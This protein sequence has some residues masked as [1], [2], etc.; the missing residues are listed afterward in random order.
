VS[1]ITDGTGTTNYSYYPVT[2]PSTLGAA[3]LE[4]IDGPLASDTVSYGY[5]EL[6]RI[7]THGLAA[8]SM[9]S[10]HDALGRFTSLGSPVGTFAWTYLNATGQPQTVT[11]PNGQV[12]TYSYLD[13]A[14]DQRLQEIKHQTSGGSVLAQFDYTYDSFGNIKTWRQQL[15]TNPAKLYSFGYDAANQ[16]TSAVQKD[17]S[18]LQILNNY[19]YAFDAVGNRTVDARD[20]VAST[21][22]YNIRN[23][24]VQQAGGGA[25]P[26]GGALS[27]AA[28]VTVN[29]TPA[30]VNSAN[31]FTGTA[32]AGTGTQTFAVTA[33]DPSGNTRTNTYQVDMSGAARTFT[34]DANGNVTSKT[35]GGLTT[36]YDWDAENRL[37]SVRQGTTTM[38]SFVYDGRGRRVQKVVGGVT[39]IYVYDRQNIIEERLSSGQTYDFVHGPETDRVL[40]QRDQAGVVT[41]YLADHLGSIAQTT[42]SA[43]AVTL[44]REY[45]PWGNLL[46][47]SGGGGYAYTGREWDSET[48][49]YYYRARY[50]DPKIG[51]FLREDPIGHASGPNLYQYVSNDPVLLVDPSGRQSLVPPGHPSNVPVP[52]GCTAKPW[53]LLDKNTVDLRTFTRWFLHHEEE[54]VQGLLEGEGES[55]AASCACIYKGPRVFAESQTSYRWERLLDCCGISKTQ[56]TTTRDRPFEHEL[57]FIGPLHPTLTIMVPATAN[58]CLCR[59]EIEVGL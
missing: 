15:G 45:D 46:Q 58:G 23:E 35:E 53:R 43:G 39:H 30:A 55:A 34:Y 26:V 14:G 17:A 11:Y 37:V 38:A 9:S 28:A 19:G 27:E 10:G 48:G 51:R 47:G 22:T 36:T 59:G 6:G 54:Y 42:S 49:L 52:K 8:F 16:L 24:L 31:Q 29:G 7:T 13:N 25:L 2:V 3:R 12:T 57:P 56:T 1:S 41:Y 20:T 21:A 18:T 32:Q 44:T 50:Y 40:A 4:S 33:T 5:D